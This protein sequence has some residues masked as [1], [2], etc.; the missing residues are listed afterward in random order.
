MKTKDFILMASLL[1]ALS[2][3]IACGKDDKEEEWMGQPEGVFEEGQVVDV[4][5]T[6]CL[7]GLR[8]QSRIGY[9]FDSALDS[10]I[11]WNKLSQEEF[12]GRDTLSVDFDYDNRLF[13]RIS[14]PHSSIYTRGILDTKGNYFDAIRGDCPGED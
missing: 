6:P 8:Y 7:I 5:D 1:L 9:D 13:I 10:L 2:L 14:T 11:V 4:L 12:I 3:C